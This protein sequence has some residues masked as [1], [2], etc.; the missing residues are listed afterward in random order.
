M[1]RR[2]ARAPKDYII[3]PLDVPSESEAKRCVELLADAVGMFKVGLELFIR[4][5][6]GIV[7]FIHSGG[8]AGVFLD[9]KLHDI[10]ATVSRA[11]AGVADLGVRL[12]SVHCGESPRMLEAAVAA[13]GG[14][15]GILGITV[16]TSVSASDLAAAGLRPELAGDL[17]GVVRQRAQVAQRA[18]CAG[19]V[20]SGLEA[21][22]IK[23]EFGRD[24]LTVT[25]GIRP[26][27]AA[28]G[29]DDQKRVATPAE[30]VR[31]GSDYLVIGRPI[32][33]ASDPR[34]AAHR[35]CAEIAAAG[36]AAADAPL[37]GGA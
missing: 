5:G 2:T 8:S 28:G 31:A 37:A 3:F 30:A 21:G 24:F 20:C 22:M 6:P 34:E 10:P 35:I 16:L 1:D 17:T 32:R 33:D 19:V 15:V 13:S 9:L 11:M 36:G 29:A 27:W 7:R 14:R 25:P 4:C 26:R 18:G 23:A 12:A